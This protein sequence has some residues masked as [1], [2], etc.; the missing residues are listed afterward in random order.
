MTIPALIGDEV[1]FEPTA[2]S[3]TDTDGSQRMS[4]TQ[5]IK[6]AGVIDYAGIP[7]DVLDHAKHRGNLVHHGCAILDRGLDLSEYEIPDECEPYIEA[8]QRFCREMEFIPDP[9]WIETPMMVNIF[10]HRV[11][12]TPDAVGTIR[13]IPTVVERKATSAAHPSWAIQTAGQ[14]MGL[15]SVGVQI[16][17]RMAVQLLRTGK[18]RPHPFDDP[19]DFQTFADAF[20]L[21]AWKVKV[22][23][24]TLA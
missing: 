20:R 19:N 11:A 15:R 5:A 17:D 12:M 3:Y 8:Y 7:T 23:L 21:A 2:H 13:G 18:Y 22:K 14:A 4:I 16:R 24:A 6:I 1:Y 10:G 9:R